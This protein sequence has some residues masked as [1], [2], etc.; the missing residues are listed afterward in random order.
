MTVLVV[1]QLK[2]VCGRLSMSVRGLCAAMRLV[3]Q[4]LSV[5]QI[6]TSNP[7]RRVYLHEDRL[8]DALLHLRV[9]GWWQ[10]HTRLIISSYVTLSQLCDER[11][12]S[13]FAPNL[14][15]A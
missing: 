3:L 2:T 10:T 9:S 12:C 13:R 6:H 14:A 8:L 7:S 4:V 5:H 1:A 15:R 11:L